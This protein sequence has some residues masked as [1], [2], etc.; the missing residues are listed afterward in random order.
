MKIGRTIRFLL[1]CAFT[2]QYAVLSA[3]GN[4]P[5][6]ETVSLDLNSSEGF[7]Q[8]RADS[9]GYLWISSPNGL[10][11]YDGYTATK[12]V[13]DPFDPNSLSQNIIYTF[14]ID[15]KDTIWLGTPEGLCK[16][17]RHK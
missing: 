6:F 5:K 4:N 12:Y 3:Q 1:V 17:D 7:V 13:N 15:N 16:F 2:V 14:W 11:K 10:Y 9:Q 8:F